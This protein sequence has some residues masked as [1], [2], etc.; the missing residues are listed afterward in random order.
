M[1]VPWDWPG[2]RWWKC[3]LHLHSPASRD[4]ADRESVTPERWVAAARAAGLDVAGVTD[5]NTGSMIGAVQVA[6]RQPG[7]PLVVLPGVELTV[8]PGVHLLILFDPAKNA[9]AVTTFLGAAGIPDA[10]LGQD[11]AHA[12]CSAIEAMEIARHRGAICIAAHVNDGKGVLAVIPAGQSL[13]EILTSELLL[14]A[15]VNTT[16]HPEL[17]AYLDGTKTGYERL[18]G[19]LARVAFSDAHS[20]GTLGT[21]TTWIKMTRPDLEGMRLALQDGPLSLRLPGPDEGDPNQHAPFAIEAI[22][23]ADSRYIG[24]GEPFLV[25]FNPWLNAVVGGRGTGKS[26]IVEFLRIALR[27]EQ[28]LQGRLREDFEEFKNVPRS[29]SDRGLL[30]EGTRLIVTYRK[31]GVCFRVQWDQQATLTPIEERETDGTWTPAE[32]DVN[33]RFPVRIYSQKQIFELARSPEALLDIIDETPEVDARTWHDRW[34]QEETRFLAL[35]AQGREVDAALAEVPRLRGQLEDITRK[36][37][38]FEGA[39]HTEVLRSYQTRKR[40]ERVVEA[41]GESFNTAGNR[42]RALAD[43]I[44]PETDPTFL[45]DDDEATLS[46]RAAAEAASADMQRIRDELLRL[47]T[48]ADSVII[49]WRRAVEVSTWRASVDAAVASYE[50]LIAK[51][52]DQGAGEPSEYGRLVQSRQTFETRLKQLEARRVALTDLEAQARASL[53]KLTALRTELTTHRAAF[54]ADILHDNPHVRIE[55]VPYGGTGSV[56][57]QLRVLLGIED[58]RFQRDIGTAEEGS[59]LL[60][61]LY[62]GYLAAVDTPDA[63]ARTQP[64]AA[65]EARLVSL[66]GRLATLAHGGSPASAVRDQRFATYMSSLVPEKLDRLAI[67]FPPDSLRISY[68]PR[69]D[70]Q[71]FRPIAEGSP[72]QKTAALLAFLL[73]YGSEPMVLDQPEDDLD[74]HLIYDLIVNQLR[75]I[76]RRR[77]VIVVTHNP[78]IVVNGDAELIIA[79]DIRG[80]QTRTICTG[81]LQEQVIR[82]EICRVMEGG[83]EAF[84]LRYRRIGLGARRA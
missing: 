27:R 36:L 78:N 37:T 8:G 18:L 15:E 33:Q 62:Q 47:A 21:R 80:G 51:L 25:R 30:T 63:L 66:K 75:A 52:R 24:R 11:H 39:G 20:V 69:N 72:G 28:E 32:G 67:W 26:S 2:S 82:D 44:T 55:V 41:W 3:D 56:E 73:S 42:F 59:G 46:L 14:A 77:Q 45:A 68:S 5:H 9:D 16:D 17:L 79:L 64:I 43:E 54:L 34:R 7:R 71:G 74:N 19:P 70:G 81:G 50:A 4:F 13:Q 83:R 76:K 6:A 53:A 35:K 49:G 61:E 12:R 31:D 23:I 38:V 84:E 40:Q 1:T 60:G 10:D 22:E 57:P 58:L 29:P 65:F 48:E